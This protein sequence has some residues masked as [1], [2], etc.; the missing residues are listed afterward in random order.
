MPP[1]D[2]AQTRRL[3]LLLQATLEGEE[4]IACIR[5]S[6]NE[7]STDELRGVF[8]LL[9]EDQRTPAMTAETLED[10]LHSHGVNASR[11]QCLAVLRQY[12]ARQK[13]FW[14]LT[15]FLNLVDKPT[16][17]RSEGRHAADAVGTPSRSTTRPGSTAT[18]LSSRGARGSHPKAAGFARPIALLVRLC[19]AEAQLHRTLEPMRRALR[20]EHGVGADDAFALLAGGA[21]TGAPP[22]SSLSLARLEQSLRDLCLP[23]SDGALECLATRLHADA[24]TGRISRSLFAEAVSPGRLEAYAERCGAVGAIPYLGVSPQR[25]S[26][27]GTVG[28]SKAARGALGRAPWSGFGGYQ[29][30][31]A[32]AGYQAGEMFGQRHAHNGFPHRSCSGEERS[33][34]GE[35]CRVS[36]RERGGG[37]SADLHNTGGAGL[38]NTGGGASLVHNTGGGA[39]VHNT[40]GGAYVHNTGGGARSCAYRDGGWHDGNSSEASGDFY[41]TS[42]T[43]ERPTPPQRHSDGRA[44]P[45][46]YGPEEAH[47]AQTQRYLAGDQAPPPRYGT[48]EPNAAPPQRHLAGDQ[49][50]PHCYQT[51]EPHSTPPQRYSDGRAPPPRYG[52]EE[53]HDAQTQRDPTGD[54]APPHR[55]QTEEPHSAPPQLY[56]AREQAPPHRYFTDEES[57]PPPTARGY[58]DTGSAEAPQTWPVCA[59]AA[60]RPAA[61]GALYLS[62]HPPPNTTNSSDTPRSAD[63]QSTG[64]ANSGLRRTAAAPARLHGGPT[65]AGL[66]PGYIS[67]D[68]QISSPDSVALN[69]HFNSCQI[70][71]PAGP[72][73]GY[74]SNS[75]QVPNPTADNHLN[76][77][78]L[79]TPAGPSRG[80]YSNSNQMPNPAAHESPAARAP[81]AGKAMARRVVAGKA[82]AGKAMAG[83]AV[84]ASWRDAPC[85]SSARLELDSDLA[86]RQSTDWDRDGDTAGEGRGPRCHTGGEGHGHEGDTAGEGRSRAQRRQRTCGEGSDYEGDTAGEG[87]SRAPRRQSTCGEGSDYKGDTAGEGR[88][89]APW[90]ITAGEG[91]GR[92]GDT[93]GEGRGGAPRCHTAGEGHGREG[94]TAGDGWSGARCRQ[95]TGG[96]GHGHERDTTGEGRGGDRCRQ[97]TGGEGPVH[98]RDTAGEGWRGA[99]R[100]NTAGEG[101]VRCL[102]RALAHEGSC[103]KA[104]EEPVSS[105][106]AARAPPVSPQSSFPP[107]AP[108]PSPPPSAAAAEEEE[109]GRAGRSHAV[110]PSQEAK[111]SRTRDLQMLKQLVGAAQLLLGRLLEPEQSTH[112]A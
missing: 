42:E 15:D 101:P 111:E 5:R 74:Y 13:G 64:P 95:S 92:K 6:L 68:N 11:L 36:W 23:L 61:D 16:L 59:A 62:K 58:F 21:R 48:G 89:G 112:S 69:N 1:L 87:R 10:F 55:Y 104:A 47:A 91:H 31:G 40:G 76:S 43:R 80:Y 93:T 75:N 57:L 90:V 12:D 81:V 24:R 99:P 38:H 22:P 84:A 71:T 102:D 60:P 44:P 45:L 2:R 78:Q 51:E 9:V 50:P 79:P 63:T 85:P 72:S 110:A 28:G 96:E 108:S 106:R 33:F 86:R 17:P 29:A 52:T 26:S 49:A 34:S 41:Y 105:V 19:E 30:V 56:L 65:H 53:A 98:E 70:P 4:R 107:R 20:N 25:P 77:C 7:A 37:G 82:M 83:K 18:P 67:N 39:D 27:A 97:S 88:S 8:A 54:Q 100:V 35:E 3:T 109:G 14:D 46:R 94:D 73:R 32:S 66:S 103:A